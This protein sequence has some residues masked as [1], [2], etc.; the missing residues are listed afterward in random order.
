VTAVV[1]RCG[2]ACS[3][4]QMSLQGHCAETA[5]SRG[6]LHQRLPAAGNTSS[7][8][9]YARCGAAGSAQGGDWLLLCT[10]RNVLL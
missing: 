9:S 10:A 3:V 2:A 7:G 5:V 6:V 4:Q 1:Y 8:C